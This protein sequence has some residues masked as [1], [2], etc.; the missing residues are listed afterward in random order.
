MDIKSIVKTAKRMGFDYVN[1]MQDEGRPIYFV[2]SSK[3]AGVAVLRNFRTRHIETSWNA[4]STDSRTASD[5]KYF[6]SMLSKALKIK[7]LLVWSM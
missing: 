3:R 7:S 5:I 2:A 4:G 6:I 1:L